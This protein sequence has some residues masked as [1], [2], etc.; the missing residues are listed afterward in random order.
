V[1]PQAQLSDRQPR[2]SSEVSAKSCP[3]PRRWQP[4][5]TARNLDSSEAVE[6]GS[7]Q[8]QVGG[9]Q[10]SWV[11]GGGDKSGDVPGHPQTGVGSGG[12]WEPAVN[13]NR[14]TR[15]IAR[16]NRRPQAPKNGGGSARREC[17]QGGSA[18][19]TPRWGLGGGVRMGP[20]ADNGRRKRAI[21]SRIRRC[22]AEK[23]GW[24]GARGGKR[25]DGGRA[26]STPKQPRRRWAVGAGRR[27]RPTDAAGR[28]R[29]QAS[30]AAQKMGGGGGGGKQEKVGRTSNTP[31]RPRRR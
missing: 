16:E 22:Q 14:R 15:A 18:P 17:N 28:Q 8:T 26:R 23:T 19:A 27:Q 25:A 30:A 10:A 24:G 11:E 5:P 9:E 1:K 12:R 21:A 4:L 3:P 29:N 20:A 31:V 6:S 2:Q 7:S 13:H